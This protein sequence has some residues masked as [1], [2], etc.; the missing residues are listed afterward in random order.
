MKAE[1]KDAD[2][3]SVVTYSI[4]PDARGFSKKFRIDS[5][6]GWVYTMVSLDREKDPTIQL[7]VRATDN[8]K[9]F[10]DR[11]LVSTLVIQCEQRSF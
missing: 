10:E 5:S 7:L 6:T 9:K 4:V 2:V 3:N 11:R 1:D 8:A